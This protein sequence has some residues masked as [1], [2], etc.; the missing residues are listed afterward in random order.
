M[1]N[2]QTALI[3]TSIASPNKALRMYADKCNEL[4]VDFIVIGDVASP[5][6]FQLDGCRFYSIQEQYDLS[7][8]LAKMLPK[9]HYSRKNLGYLL[10]KDKE[11]I[12]ETDDDNL[13]EENF[14]NARTRTAEA[15]NV[16][17]KGWFNAYH[18][19]SDQNLWPRGFPVEAIETKHPVVLA[20]ISADLTSV[21]SPVQQ[22]LANG[23]PDVDAIFRIT[24]GSPVHFKT[25]PPLLLSEGTWCPFN[26]QNTTWFKEAFPL[27]YLPSYCSFRMTD[28]W[29][30][31][32]AQRIAWTCN[33]NIL[34]HE[35]TVYQE[36]NEHNLLKDFADEIPGYLNN[37][38]ICRLLEDLDLRNGI[39]NISENL[40]RCYKLMTDKKYVDSKELLLLDAWIYDL[41]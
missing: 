23:N 11:V 32:V 18:Y 6:D 35:A 21:E 9:K 10:A 38:Q 39:N 33:W 7:F 8:R 16:K 22:G 14:W 19:F 29:R 31:F 5:T 13:P 40:L 15:R 2:H 30:S 36:R 34:S 4:G 37:S 26:S 41:L 20:G 27:L 17:A 24:L 28:I 25:N 1:M 12:V 3:I